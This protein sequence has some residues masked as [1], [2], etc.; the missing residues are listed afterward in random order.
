LH[1]FRDIAGFCAHN[2]ALFHP[3]LGV[4]S[5]HQIAAIWP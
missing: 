5:L 4:F 2:P 1:H 3:N